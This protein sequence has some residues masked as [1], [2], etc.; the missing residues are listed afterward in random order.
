MQVRDIMTERLAFCSPDTDLREV[1][2]MMVESDCGAIPVVEPE[3]G[4]AIGIVTDRDI[5]CRTVAAGQNPVGRR[6]EEAMTM[7]IAAV[8]PGSPLEECVAEMESNRLRRMLVVDE[9]GRLCGIVSQADVA[10]AAGE[11]HTAEL[12]KD[13]SKPTDYPSKLQ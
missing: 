2:R 12:V 1:A 3:S 10:R 5:V 9:Q 13:V 4:K 7:P 11:H 6:A 8:S